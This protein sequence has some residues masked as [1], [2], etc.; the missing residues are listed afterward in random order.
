MNPDRFDTLTKR[1]TTGGRSRRHIV[2]GLLGGMLGGAVVT[3]E[4][5]SAAQSATPVAGQDAGAM[6]LFLYVQT[7]GGGTLAPLD[8]DPDRYLLTLTEA[9]P[10]TV[11]FAD[12][13][14]RE[15]DLL[16]TERLPEVLAFSEDNPPNAALVSRTE[17]GEVIVLV[18]ELLKPTYDPD[19]RT[20]TYEVIELTEYATFGDEI[21]ARAQPPGSMPSSFGITNLFIDSGGDGEDGSAVSCPE[22]LTDCG[23]GCVDLNSDPHHCGYCGA[24]CNGR[25]GVIPLCINSVCN[26]GGCE[27]GYRECDFDCYAGGCCTDADCGGDCLFCNVNHTC[28]PCTAEGMDCQDGSCV[29]PPPP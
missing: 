18:I 28:L 15:T 27:P 16:P 23:D 20:V 19:T 25:P 5:R 12:R 24:S 13:P 3:N 21:A 8:N 29:P 1:L 2:R 26:F 22:G 14:S 4:A 10:M 6:P 11:V 17:G 7:F 9:P